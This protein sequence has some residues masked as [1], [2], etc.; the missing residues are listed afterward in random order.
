MGGDLAPPASAAAREALTEAVN[1][2]STLG[3]HLAF[4]EMLMALGSAR[5]SGS[6]EVALE[7]LRAMEDELERSVSGLLQ[8]SGVVETLT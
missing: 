2:C 4:V 6:L 1:R 5:E 8:T 7:Q 3:K